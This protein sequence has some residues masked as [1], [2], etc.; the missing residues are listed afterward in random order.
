MFQTIT[1]SSE[2]YKI[3]VVDQPVRAGGAPGP[4]LFVLQGRKWPGYQVGFLMLRKPEG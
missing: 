2:H 1:L 4:R 3:T